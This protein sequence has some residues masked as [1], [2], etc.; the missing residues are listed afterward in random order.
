MKNLHIFLSLIMILICSA[1]TVYA[2]EFLTDLDLLDKLLDEAEL[3]I[4]T[5]TL[6][7]QKISEAPAT[8]IVVT[9]EQIQARC[10]RSLTD[11]LQDL[12]DIKVDIAFESQILNGF[13]VR[14]VQGLEKM[15]ILLD[16]DRISS[17]TGDPMAILENY[18]VHFAKRIE[19]IYGPASAL[20]GADAFSGVINIISKDKKDING[21]ETSSAF[22][23]FGLYHGSGVYNIE[24]SDKASLL[25]SGQYFYDKQ[26]DLSE[27]YPDDFEGIESLQTGTFHTIFGERTPERPVSPDYDIPIRAYTFYAKL[28]AEK[29]KFSLFRT[30]SKVP[31]ATG[32]TPHNAVYNSDAFWAQTISMASA[33]YTTDIWNMNSVTSIQASRYNLDPES[34]FRNVYVD[35]ELAYKYAFG[36]MTKISQQL[37]HD[38]ADNFRITSGITYESFYSVPKGADLAYPV[39]ENRAIASAI[40]GTD[41]PADFFTVRYTNIGGFVQAQYYPIPSLSVTGGIRYDYNSRFKETVNPRVGA[42][43]NPTESTNIKV[44]YGTAFLAPSPH[45]AFSHYGSF[46]YNDSLQTYESSFWHLPNP[47]LKPEE[48]S[49]SEIGIHQTIDSNFSASLTAYYS[50]LKDLHASASD[51]GH[52]QLYNHSYKGYSVGYIEIAINK[53]EQINYGGTLRI[54]YKEKFGDGN[55]IALYASMSYVDG[56]ID[57]MDE[58]IEI[59]DIAPIQAHTGGEIFWKNLTFSPRLTVVGAQRSAVLE[60]NGKTRKT[61]DGYALLDMSLHY[62]FHDAHILKG[63]SL[64]VNVE[65]ITDNRYYNNNWGAFT[66][67]NFDGSPQNPRRFIGGIVLKRAK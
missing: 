38:V 27:Y 60:D 14:G 29:F 57:Q 17:P 59:E 67:K 25:I 31:N 61:T 50:V 36:S 15:T 20:Y 47:D 30:F 40:A 13:S 24:I 44:L 26:P 39:D 3:I 18:P 8:A 58:K 52:T 34:G 55:K 12:P 54:N 46:S 53:G 16:G 35:M 37:S 1:I 64:F 22:G 4:I 65:N 48:L 6:H 49:M 43:W 51:D 11:V 9:G 32:Y 45:A 41:I 28:Q 62:A 23:S 2:E 7:E 63:V 21:I 42:I 56:E 33:T 10:Y 66:D 5:A 19:I